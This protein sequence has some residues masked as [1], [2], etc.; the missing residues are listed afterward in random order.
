MIEP[1]QFAVI[2]ATKEIHVQQAEVRALIA[3]RID[4]PA[5]RRRL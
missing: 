3:S 5:F 1:F 4:L 2:D